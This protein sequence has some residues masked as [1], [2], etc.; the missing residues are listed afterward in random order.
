[1][2]TSNMLNDYKTINE[3]L[4]N[5]KDSELA[6][7]V[8]NYEKY[9]Y[10][11]EI[12]ENIFKILKERNIDILLLKQKLEKEK[13]D[14]IIANTKK[15]KLIKRNIL[16][17]SL[18]LFLY[19]ISIF[20]IILSCLTIKYFIVPFSGLMQLI[21]NVYAYNNFLKIVDWKSEYDPIKLLR[22]MFFLII[23]Q[24]FMIIIIIFLIVYNVKNIKVQFTV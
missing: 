24:P 13:N 3:K 22:N 9:G 21:I 12:L 19:L 1:M 4:N 11:E 10:S 5:L 15:L 16:I 8:K 7:I 2:K 14:Q 6:D 20:I 18:I 17:Y 23:L